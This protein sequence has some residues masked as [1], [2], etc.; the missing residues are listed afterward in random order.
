MKNLNGN[1]QK[2]SKEPISKLLNH[3]NLL[4][5]KIKQ[6]FYYNDVNPN[7]NN[8]FIDFDRMEEISAY[9]NEGYFYSAIKYLRDKPN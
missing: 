1:N 6:D 8:E 2:I 9:S 4:N 7:V 3:K 5:F